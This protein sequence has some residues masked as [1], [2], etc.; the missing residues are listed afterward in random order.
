MSDH[1]KGCLKLDKSYHYGN[2]DERIYGS[3]VEHMGRVVYEGIYEPEHPLA[4]A[5]GFRQDVMEFARALHIPIVRYPG[6]NFVSGYNWEDGVGPREQRP[7]KL[8]LAW[9]S[10]ETNQFGTNEFINWC[11]KTGTAPMMAVN[12]GT[13]GADAARNLVEYCNMS[14]GT[15][16]SDLRIKHGWKE[17][18]NVKLWCLGNEMDG[19]WQIGHKTAQEYGRIACEAAKVMKWTDPSIELVACGSSNSSMPNFPEWDRVVLENTYDQIEYMSMHIYY[20]EKN[21]DTSD[22]LASGVDMDRFIRSM[23]SVCDYVKSVKRGKK[24][25]YLS[26]DEWNVT[27]AEQWEEKKNPW[28]IAPHLGECKY[29]LADAI[30]MGSMLNSLIRHSSRIKVACQAQLVNLLGPIITDS[31]GNAWR[32]STYWPVFYASNYGR[33]KSLMVISESPKHSTASFDD[34][35]YLDSTAVWNEPA[36]EIT[37]FAINRHLSQ[38]M[39]LDIDLRGM[40]NCRLIEHIELSHDNIKACNTPDD[41]NIVVPKPGTGGVIDEGIFTGMILPH[42][43]NMFRF[44]IEP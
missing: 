8:E 25:I 29:N 21:N 41:H 15:Y 14:E 9:N 16:Y 44:S 18:H 24:D 6:G 39:E 27:N 38:A 35:P 17:S 12:L 30:V 43:W 33:G 5:E 10:T 23:I 36:A 11:K 40:G 3:F 2:I 22:Y 31:K 19:P 13:R 28:E 4:D 26:F 37:V 7:R 1:I 34:V 32:Q 42:S 20:E